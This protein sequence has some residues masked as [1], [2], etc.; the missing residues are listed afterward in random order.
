MKAIKISGVEELAQKAEVGKVYEWTDEYDRTFKV[1]VTDIS[2]N[3][4]TG[5]IDVALRE[6]WQ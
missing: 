6:I 1:E 4:L 5:K 3:L 2:V